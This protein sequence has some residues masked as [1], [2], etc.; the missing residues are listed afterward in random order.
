LPPENGKL[1]PET[2]NMAAGSGAPPEIAPDPLWETDTG[3]ETATATLCLKSTSTA[4]LVS[5]ALQSQTRFVALDTLVTMV[6][7]GC[8]PAN[9]GRN[10]RAHIP[11]MKLIM[12]GF[13]VFI[14]CVNRDFPFGF[15]PTTSVTLLRDFLPAPQD[16]KS[17]LP[18]L[19]RF[20]SGTGVDLLSGAPFHTLFHPMRTHLL[21]S[22]RCFDM[23]GLHHDVAVANLSRPIPSKMARNNSR[24]IATSAIWK[25]ICR[26][27]RT[28]FAPILINFSRN[29]VKVQ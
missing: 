4:I 7:L 23:V 25:I 21:R 14:Y 13:L 22:F 26:A 12:T 17:I 5:P 3:Y 16:C 9:C 29:V 15:L 24:G 11:A 28:T 6:P 1:T 20:L 19:H 27:W 18:V 8:A 10:A 2:L